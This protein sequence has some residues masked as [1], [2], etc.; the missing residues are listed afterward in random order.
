MLGLERHIPPRGAAASMRNSRCNI[1]GFPASH[2]RIHIAQTS[3]TWL[4]KK[5]QKNWPSQRTSHSHRI[6]RRS[7]VHLRERR[8]FRSKGFS[9]SSNFL[10]QLPR[11]K[12]AVGSSQDIEAANILS[13]GLNHCTLPLWGQ[14]AIFSTSRTVRFKKEEACYCTKC[15]N[16]III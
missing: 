15:A 2:L 6:P 4:P 7:T 5:S 10:L 8:N 16:W 9:R 11:C 3:Q 14:I 12:G 13:E 1:S